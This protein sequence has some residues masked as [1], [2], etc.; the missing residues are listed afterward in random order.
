M[1]T[2]ETDMRRELNAPVAHDGFPA[3]FIHVPLMDGNRSRKQIFMN[4][5]LVSPEK[6]LKEFDNHIAAAQ[7]YN[8]YAKIYYLP[9]IDAL[10]EIPDCHQE[11]LNRLLTFQLDKPGKGEKDTLKV[12]E[13][14]EEAHKIVLSLN[15]DET[16]HLLND[17]DI[18]PIAH[19]HGYDMIVFPEDRNGE[20]ESPDEWRKRTKAVA[21]HLGP[22]FADVA[23]VVNGTF[24]NGRITLLSQHFPSLKNK[25]DSIK[26]DDPYP[27]IK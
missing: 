6:M 20:I 14:F 10:F 11:T 15:H 13:F 7:Y 16:R 4:L 9:A 5:A 3:I 18:K 21:R 12:R 27:E 19:E 24:E 8:S 23:E 2:F 17:M 1:G 25:M 22:I 26:N